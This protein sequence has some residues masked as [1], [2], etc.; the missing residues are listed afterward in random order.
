M[1]QVG[2][3]VGMSPE[4]SWTPTRGP[5]SLEWGWSQELVVPVPR[6]HGVLSPTSPGLLWDPG[7][8]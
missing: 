3:N 8:L 4:V 2:V 6:A 1:G 5:A 7:A